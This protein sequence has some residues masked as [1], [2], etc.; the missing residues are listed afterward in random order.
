MPGLML[1]NKT[2]EIESRL[3]RT[4]Q[5]FSVEKVG[6]E[7]LVSWLM[8]SQ[9]VHGEGRMYMLGFWHESLEY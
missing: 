7:S 2:K 1:K 8:V 4:L 5:H 3:I 6:I 9:I